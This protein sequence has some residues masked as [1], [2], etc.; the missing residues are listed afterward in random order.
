MFEL[1]DGSINFNKSD[2]GVDVMESWAFRDVSECGGV[3]RTMIVEDVIKVGSEH[4][5]IVFAI[6]GKFTICHFHCHLSLL[7]MVDSSASSKKMDIFP[8]NAWV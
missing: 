3:D 6:G 5:H 8:C 2:G 4:C 1:V 7:F